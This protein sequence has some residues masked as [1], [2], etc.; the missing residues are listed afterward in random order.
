MNDLIRHTKI[1]GNFLYP[2]IKKEAFRFGS[3]Q[4]TGTLLRPDGDWRPFTPPEELQ[5]IRGIESS[6]CYV[7]ASQHTIATILEEQYKVIDQNYS[8][9]FNALLSDGTEQ[10]GSPIDG[11]QSIR[12]DGLIPDALLPFSDAVQSWEDFHSFK[13]GDET[14]CREEGKNWLAQWKPEY[15]IVIERLDSV[16]EKFKKL[17]DALK[18]SP[19]PISVTAWYEKDGLYIKPAF[20]RDNHLVECVFVDEENHPYIWDTYAPFLKKLDKNY[21]FE[22]GMRWG[23]SKVEE[24]KTNIY[25]DLAKRLW[26]FFREMASLLKYKI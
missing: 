8:S 6:A 9:R 21:D 19:I 5:N 17:K 2:Q 26:E 1:K 4:L 22:F 15:D 20:A 25:L 23:I 12:H 24:K 16:D 7:E 3:R 13:G 10:G 18:Y 11:A 14:K